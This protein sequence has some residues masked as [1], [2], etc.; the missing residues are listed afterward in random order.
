MD[1]TARTALPDLVPV[2]MYKWYSAFA[3]EVE[4][5]GNIVWK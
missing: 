5:I 4:A 1:F 2:I 3:E